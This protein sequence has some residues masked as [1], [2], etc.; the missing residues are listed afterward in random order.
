[1]LLTGVKIHSELEGFRNLDVDVG[2]DVILV[3][4]GGGLL[5]Y[6]VLVLS[7]KLDEVCYILPPPLKFTP[8]LCCSETG[9]MI[10]SNQ[11]VLG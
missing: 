9:L 4:I 2:T 3:V 5:I 1:M 11:F 7:V 8:Y 10:S 6:T